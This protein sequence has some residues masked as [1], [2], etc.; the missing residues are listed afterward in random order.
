MDN[1]ETVATNALTVDIT[2]IVKGSF[3]NSIAFGNIFSSVTANI[4]AET[5]NIRYLGNSNFRFNA[6][7]VDREI[8]LGNASLSRDP[9]DN[10][11][12]SGNVTASS[13]SAQ[14]GSSEPTFKSLYNLNLYANA[15]GGGGAVVVTNTPVRFS[16][17]TT[18]QRDSQLI[19]ANGDVI[20]NITVNRLQVYADF[21]WRDLTL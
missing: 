11:I 13:F 5:S 19:P 14:G 1:V 15:S 8:G 17:F 6:I 2:Y 16:S 3:S 21:A 20:M 18:S 12:F 10:L 7:Y 4:L 9:Q